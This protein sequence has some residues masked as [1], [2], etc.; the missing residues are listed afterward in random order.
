[1]KPTEFKLYAPKA[2]RVNIAGTFNGWNTSDL[3]AKKDSRGNWLVK[4]NLKPGRHEYKFI[5]DGSWL[6]DPNSTTLVTNSF[7]TQNSVVEVK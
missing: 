6:N 7:G 4:V 3:S 5:V 1:M 2:R